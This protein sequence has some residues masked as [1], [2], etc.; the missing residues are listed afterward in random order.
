M[1][2][3]LCAPLLGWLL[4]V[5]PLAGVQEMRPLATWPDWR[6][7]PFAGWPGKFEAW[8]NDHFPLRG[9]VVQWNGL[10][11]HR[12]LAEPSGLVV[13]GRDDWLFYTGDKT[14]QDLFG[15]DRM[16]EGELTA[17]REAAEGRRAWW[18]ERGAHY[19]LVLVP[20]KSTVYP[21]K[22][23]AFL[24]TQ[25]RGGKLDQ[26]VEHLRTRSSP[27]AVVDLRA[28]LLAAK[29]GPTLYW[30]TD[31]HW[32]AGGLVAASDAIMA[33][34][35][36][37][38]VPHRVRDEAAWTKIEHATRAGDCIGLLAMTG[39]WPLE[40]VTQLR[41][42]FPP[43]FR[44]S[45]TPVSALPLWQPGSPWSWP[46]A[47]E[48]DSGVGRTV[49]FCDSFFRVGGLADDALAQ[50]PLVLN[51]KRFVS[52]WNW[53]GTQNLAGYEMVSAI[54]EAE[55]PT[56][57]IEQWTERY[58]RTRPPDHPEFQRARGAKAN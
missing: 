14:I 7:T 51:F 42:T 2:G 50:A 56:L 4:R 36:E 55:R 9:R 46:L 38:G 37:L 20:N 47:F 54:A 19:L 57:V 8:L 10:V 17:W 44:A 24:R 45:P 40:P 52:V 26:L 39:R 16:N 1:V 18:R 43:D 35:G 53:I 31:S 27:V 3:L 12:W 41:L 21:E 48:R 22:L 49:M 15:R 28:A 6:A 32:S 33:R 29:S 58:L 25:A 5:P 13:V 30:P 34:L 11:R 23:P